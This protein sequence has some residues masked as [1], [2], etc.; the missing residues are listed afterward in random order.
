MARQVNRWEKV[1]GFYHL[2]IMYS[3]LLAA[4]PR[5]MG[6]ELHSFTYAQIL[7]Q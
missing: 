2:L 1:F 5:T 7:F 4:N 3:Y 6:F